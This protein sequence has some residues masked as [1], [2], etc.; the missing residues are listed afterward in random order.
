MKLSLLIQGGPLSTNAPS[1]A[2]QFAREA[3]NQGHAL[4]RVFLY[5]DAVHLANRFNSVP[6][7]ETYS[8]ISLWDAET[9][10]NCWYFD[11]MVAPVPGTTGG[12]FV[13]P[14]GQTIDHV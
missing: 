8:H 12:A 7:D 9:A 11:A 2:L 1:I 14:I 3:V 10:G 5:K 6:A 4:Y 13:F